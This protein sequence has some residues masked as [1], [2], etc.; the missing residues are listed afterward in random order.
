MS[1]IDDTADKL[2]NAT[3]KAAQGNEGRGEEHR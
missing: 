1:K 2:K 3:G